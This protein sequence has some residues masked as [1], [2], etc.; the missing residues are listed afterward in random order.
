MDLDN[1][2]RSTTS[3]FRSLIPFA[4]CGSEEMATIDG[5]PTRVRQHRWGVINI[6]D[7]NHCDFSAIR[8]FI[9][10]TH[11]AALVESTSISHY[12]NFR[13]KQLMALKEASKAHQHS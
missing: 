9:I 12:E 3:L 1:D 6:E 4:V 5:K 13:T 7:P 2:D 10:R 11:L 8:D